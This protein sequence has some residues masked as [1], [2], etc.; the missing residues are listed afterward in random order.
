MDNQSKN[1]VAAIFMA[2]LVVGT[3]DLS[4]AMIQTIIMGREPLK[5]LQYISS[6]M[7]GPQAFE[8]GLIYAALGVFFHYFIAFSW[9][10]IFFL[11]YPKIKFFAGNS[12]VTCIVYGLIVWL[13]MNRVVVPLS[14]IPSRPFN[15]NNA[16]IGS[17]ILIIAIGIPLSIMAHRFYLN[18]N[19]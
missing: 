12:V 1:I 9:T 19:I 5:L 18:K 6:G 17:G 14:K 16:L 3:L 2:G 11:I 7:F 15:L 13:I 4:A 10:V 8:G